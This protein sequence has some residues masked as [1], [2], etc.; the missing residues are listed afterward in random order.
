MYRKVLKE[1]E[2]WKKSKDRKPLIL[3]GARQVGKTWL[4]QHFGEENYSSVVYINMEDTP[5]MEEV[6]APD[7][8][9]E[10]ILRA[11]ENIKNVRII[12]GETLLIFDEIQAVPRALSSLKYFCENAPEY[13][14]AVAG[15]LLGVALHSGTSFPVG[16]VDSVDV[17]PMDF[18][19]FLKAIGEDGYAKVISGEGVSLDESPVF[20]EK[21]TDYLRAYMVVGG[22]PEAV[23]NYRRGENFAK[24]REIQ[25]QI[26]DAYELD[27]SKHAPNADTPKIREIYDVAPTFLSR[28]NK[29]F[30]FN[31]IRE[32][33]RAR[34]YDSALLWMEDAG[35]VSRVERVN[36]VK[37][38]LKAYASRNIFKLFFSDIGLLGAKAQIPPQTIMDSGVLFEE[39][40]GAFAEQFV[41]QELRARKTPTYYYSNDDSKG[42]IDFLIQDEDQIVPVEVKSG[43]N[44]ASVSLNNFV[45][46]WDIPRGVKVSI[47][48]YKK[49]DK[50]DNFPLYL[51]SRI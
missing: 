22:M 41:F 13:H 15:S 26:I 7:L 49:N 1:L 10:R 23:D 48:P 33:A 40:K 5:G 25:A 8:D 34:E 17:L 6:F 30:V 14:V 11:I 21:L 28:E 3:S 44:L 31:A 9:V 32:S 38:P 19:E 42:E 20:H 4:L 18:Y 2:K 46:K 24:I 51:V 16:K 39:Y 45:S 27:F 37:I 12:P 47:L 36:A 29:K 43:K 35:L 50:I